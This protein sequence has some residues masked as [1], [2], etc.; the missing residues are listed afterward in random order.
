MGNPSQS[1]GASRAIWNHSVL[2]QL[3]CH[4]KQ[5]N[6]P[7]LKRKL[8]RPQVNPKACGI[9]VLYM[10]YHRP[11]LTQASKLVLDLPTLKGWT[12]ELT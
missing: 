1:Y 12:T 5:V 4:P 10:N 11:W 9:A 6:A 7:R 2:S 3:I 8:T